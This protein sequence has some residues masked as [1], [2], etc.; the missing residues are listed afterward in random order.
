MRSIGAGGLG[1]DIEIDFNG[2]ALTSHLARDWSAATRGADLWNTYGPTECTVAVSAQPWRDDPDLS[3]AGVVS[4]GTAFP[5]CKAALLD[6]DDIVPVGPQSSSLVG[7]LLLATPQCFDGYLDPALPSPFIT[8]D[9][10]LKYYRTGD[11]VLARGARL[12][13]LGRLDHQVKIRGHRIDRL[14]ERG[15]ALAPENYLYRRDVNLLD[16]E[17]LLAQPA[18]AMP[19]TTGEGV[20]NLWSQRLRGVVLRTGALIYQAARDPMQEWNLSDCTREAW[21]REAVWPSDFAFSYGEF[22]P[23]I[24]LAGL[25]E[26][27]EAEVARQAEVRELRDWQSNIPE[28]TVYPYDFEAAWRRGEVD[29]LES[30][31]RHALAHDSEVVLLALP[32]YAY[33]LDRAE[34]HDFVSRFGDKVQLFDLHGAV[35]ADFAPLWYDDAHVERSP[36]G[37]LTTAVMA[38]RLLQSDALHTL[39]SERDG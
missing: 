11:R 37:R 24:E 28:G 19:F 12:F 9:A 29:I 39:R 3:Q 20:F 23:D 26:A 17:Q 4:I 36:V 6:G 32:L 2:E 5:D 30:M 16:F 7:E 13:H 22:E 38:Q 8:D 18:V 34:L 25:V 1:P 31:I 33:E 27:L 14:A 15:L 21:T 35:E 10:G